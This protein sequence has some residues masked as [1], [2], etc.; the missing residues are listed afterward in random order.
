MKRAIKTSRAILALLILMIISLSLFAYQTFGQSM[1]RAQAFDRTSYAATDIVDWWVYKW[2][3]G[4]NVLP[5]YTA[6]GVEFTIAGQPV[7]DAGTSG[8]VTYGNNAYDYR[9]RIHGSDKANTLFDIQNGKQ[10]SIRFKLDMQDTGALS[11]NQENG[12]GGKRF[13]LIVRGWMGDNEKFNN[14]S[15][16]YEL[17]RIRFDYS[18]GTNDHPIRLLD[19]VANGDWAASVGEG[20]NEEQRWISSN[21][22]MT[23]EFYYVFDTTNLMQT[24]Y[25]QNTMIK[26]L[27]DTTVGDEATEHTQAW[28]AKTIKDRITAQG[29][30]HICFDIMGDAGFTQDVKLLITEIN[31]ESLAE[32][33]SSGGGD[34]VVPPTTPADVISPMGSSSA[35][36][37]KSSSGV[38]VTDVPL[39][40]VYSI[41]KDVLFDARDG[42]EIS[43]TVPKSM[44]S[45]TTNSLYNAN[46][47]EFVVYKPAVY[48]WDDTTARYNS[49]TSDGVLQDNWMS[50]V[51]WMDA[52]D[53]VDRNS[54]VKYKMA[55]DGTV[56]E[57]KDT[58]WLG[59]SVTDGI[60][61]SFK[62]DSY[63]KLQ[64][65]DKDG[66]WVTVENGTSVSAGVGSLIANW[67]TTKLAV[68]LRITGSASN[69]EFT[70]NSVDGYS[71]SSADGT[72]YDYIP[73]AVIKANDVPSV[74]VQGSSTVLD[75][76]GYD[77]FGGNKMSLSIT[78]PSGASSTVE[79]ANGYTFT[80]SLLGDYKL[81]YYITGANGVTV[82]SEE[83]VI[84][85]KN[86]Y[87]EIVITLDGTYGNNVLSKNDTITILGIASN[88][89][90]AS[91]SVEMIKP[92]GTTEVVSVGAQYTFT[93][94]GIYNLVY[95]AKDDASP[96]PNE[97]TKTITFNIVDST[98]PV[99]NITNANDIDNTK[100]RVI[101]INNEFSYVLGTDFTVVDDS[102]VTIIGMLYKTD[103]S[104]SKINFTNDKFTFTPDK[105]GTY[106]IEITVQDYYGN[107]TTV[108]V[109]FVVPAKK[110]VVSII[111]SGFESKVMVPVVYKLGT[112]FT[113]EFDGA[114]TL[115][116][117]LVEDEGTP[118]V[119]TP[120]ADNE[121]T[122]TPTKVE[123]FYYLRITATGD[124]GQSTI[125]TTTVSIKA[126]KS[127]LPVITITNP[128]HNNSS[129]G[130]V[131][132]LG[133]FV[134]TLGT[135]FTVVDDTEYTLKG[136]VKHN[137]VF[138]DLPFVDGKFTINPEET[139]FYYLQIV[140]TDE[141]GE[142]QQP[143]T[144]VVF[145]KFTAP[146]VTA[147]VINILNDNPEEIEIGSVFS[148]VLGTD[149][150]VTDT[151]EVTI[152]GSAVKSGE[153]AIAMT[154]ADD[155]LS[156]T[157]T[158]VGTY[159]I[160]INAKDVANNSAE[161]KTV[162]L[163]VKEKTPPTVTIINNNIISSEINAE[164]NYVLG[165]D[166]TVTYSG[167]YTVTGTLT[168]PDATQEGI[169]FANDKFTFTPTSYGTYII[170]IRVQ[171][172]VYSDVVTE[173]QVVLNFQDASVD[174]DAPVITIKDEIKVLYINAGDTITLTLGTD[175]TVSDISDIE[176]YTVKLAILGAE[177]YTEIQ[178]VDN[179]FSI[180]I[181]KSGIHYMIICAKD[182]FGNEGKSTSIKINVMKPTLTITNTQIFDF[183]LGETITL[184]KGT[185][186]NII[187]ANDVEIDVKLHGGDIATGEAVYDGE[188]ITFVPKDGVNNYYICITAVDSFGN[189]SASQTISVKVIT[190]TVPEITITNADDSDITKGISKNLNDTLSYVLGTDFTIT[191]GCN[192]TATLVKPNG[193]RND[194]SLV[195]NKFDFTFDLVG[196]YYLQL[197][198]TNEFGAVTTSTTVYIK[199][200]AP[201]INIV[202]NDTTN[203]VEGFRGQAF[204]YALGTDFTVSP[205]GEYQYLAT[206][207]KPDGTQETLTF[208]DG[209]FSFVP[210][211]L[212]NYY[213]SIIAVVDANLSTTVSETVFIKMSPIIP[214]IVI[215]NTNDTDID[216]G[217]NINV[218]QAF[219]YELNTDFTVTEGF[220]VTAKL[221]KADG[222][223]EDLTFTD[224]KFSFTP[225]TDGN[226][227]LNITA[228]DEFG[229]SAIS[230]TVYFR[231]KA[232]AINVVTTEITDANIGQEISFVLGTDFSVSPE[233]DYTYTAKLVKPGST[234]E[235]DLE[236][237]SNKFT[238]TPD[239]VGNYYI[240]IIATDSLGNTAI[241][242]TISVKVVANPPVIEITNAD[243]I[244]SEIGR[245]I[246][247][248]DALSF[249]LGTDFTISPESATVT[250]K[251]SKP[252][253]EV[254]DLTITDGRLDLTLNSAGNYYLSIVATNE[255]GET[256]TSDT[257][258]IRV[259][260]STTIIPGTGN[261]PKGNPEI[262]FL[263]TDYVGETGYQLA[264]GDRNFILKNGRDFNLVLNSE[265]EYTIY[266]RFVAPQ[267]DEI[268][269]VEYDMERGRFKINNED[270]E[271]AGNYYLQIVIQ[272]DEGNALKADTVNI[273]VVDPEAEDR[274]TDPTFVIYICLCG[275][276]IVGFAV[277]RAVK[278][279][280][281]GE[282]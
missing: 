67:N 240:R 185:D 90:I 126:I 36:I 111:N 226:Y 222:S 206:L 31:G 249:V 69:N 51:V 101:E 40:T 164:F 140:A 166:F 155:K 236:F 46:A 45:G 75:V 22:S 115:S 8:G 172:S 6:E 103:G 186:F 161:A 234:D 184:V 142:P 231:A 195:D 175:F 171:D 165:T 220:S 63:G 92:D 82:E 275:G 2:E 44:F 211:T 235:T 56:Y 53:G 205:E 241:A 55:G 279:K 49:L 187:N 239:V 228:T 194:Y 269:I 261:P 19:N 272:D 25:N 106:G 254:I 30:T 23:S 20:P 147:P 26:P 15:M 262:E 173:K 157:P 77:L 80:P 217:R 70:V 182:E 129:V 149:F 174:T 198:L 247:L 62:Y 190:V 60:M 79:A 116:A 209:K 122:F 188:K 86:K 266:G 118:T 81:K 95:T 107:Y 57:V 218:G 248:G 104:S 277:F 11:H 148:F 7:K 34:V 127:D 123:T 97:N 242:S 134:Y 98:P 130:I 110:P 84:S 167:E 83:Y 102:S 100:G 207:E 35:S 267:S 72:N 178:L 120:N 43:I 158:S 179:K 156:F 150:T 282:D 27:L 64:A 139:G 152:T 28:S 170:T 3:N 38:R 252:S 237:T 192:V 91:S 109:Y 52:G 258:F 128:D 94:C 58:G 168:K 112:D 37:T 16:E 59:Q 48:N 260:G 154:F 131:K 276:I 219:S 177:P 66:V 133:E 233:G 274:A 141:S 223:T 263:N 264:L 96:T 68:G 29:I 24:Y 227:Y 163:T 243:D 136:I 268:V 189:K 12:N 246:N 108:R 162:T 121:F 159:T 61:L 281:K 203:G 244:N 47:I 232:I 151:S 50:I 200:V 278:G 14:T 257:I 76:Y 4:A 85:V 238:F 33:A 13:D 71:L 32:G 78:D 225:T 265:E 224:N 132:P 65:K 210:E 73:D 119:L 124:N 245:E 212:G 160:T 54:A 253:G 250:A 280:G 41:G 143:E 196:N 137:N 88:P 251:L 10:V 183:A 221:N 271:V 229:N 125:A 256:A 197:T 144:A 146:D 87:T 213:L 135:D 255:V 270:F 191:E 273:K 5:Q 202:T 199:V 181:E 117:E 39:N 193:T 89:N 1:K 208:A 176:S 153:S 105:T 21:P 180:T 9:A 204:N 145:I 17:F 74:V 169:A 113:V 201:T 230:D 93:G 18:A 42:R 138:T 114:Y 216:T 215:V 259:K 99:I 214:E